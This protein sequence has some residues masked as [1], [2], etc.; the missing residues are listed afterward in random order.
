MIQLCKAV[1]E[2]ACFTGNASFI[3]AGE[4]GFQSENASSVVTFSSEQ[5]QGIMP[6]KTSIIAKAKIANRFVFF[7]FN[8]PSV[9]G[10]QRQNVSGEYYF[11][12][13]FETISPLCT[14]SC[15]YG[16]LIPFLRYI[17]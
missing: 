10:Y 14:V 2:A 6:V 11:S 1:I 9:F 8:P 15:G 12:D 7:I 13:F 17:M 16:A 3:D 4:S 5:A